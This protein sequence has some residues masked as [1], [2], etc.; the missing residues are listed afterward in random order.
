MTDTPRRK[1]NLFIDDVRMTDYVKDGRIYAIA[2]DISSAK[3]LCW[4]FGMPHFISFDHDLGHGED[5]MQ[6]AKWLANEFYIEQIHKIPDYQ[7][8]SDNP[9]GSLNLQAYMNSWVKS[10]SL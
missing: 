7:V 9:V 1:W 2:R 10:Q 3:S 6:F 4:A 5:S 8:H